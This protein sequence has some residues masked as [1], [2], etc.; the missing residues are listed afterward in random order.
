MKRLVPVFA[1]IVLATV[2][3]AAEPP[4]QITEGTAVRTTDGMIDLKVSWQ[5]G[6]C[7]E[8]GEARVTAGD[9]TTDEVTI[10]TAGTSE[11]CTMQIVPVTYEETIV[12]E[13][14]TSALAVIVLS[15]DGQ[16][17]AIGTIAIAEPLSSD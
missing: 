2:G 3:V 16:P 11:I 15:P 17:V 12:V 14:R 6:A 1:A 10:P 9:E 7:E 8:I 5:G 13:P 4:P